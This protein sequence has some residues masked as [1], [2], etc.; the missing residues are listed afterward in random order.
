MS[1]K[2]SPEIKIKKE[3]CKGCE[4]CVVRCPLKHIEMSRELNKKGVSFARIKE[5][6]KC[7]GCGICFFICP[8]S[9]IEVYE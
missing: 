8:D 3:R 9:C 5:G 2:K 7:S 4:L 6:T 1:S